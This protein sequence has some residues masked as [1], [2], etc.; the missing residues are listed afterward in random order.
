MATESES[1]RQ[2]KANYIRLHNEGY[3]P[4]EIA[5][6]FNLSYSHVLKKTFEIAEENGVDRDSLLIQVHKT[7][8]YWQRKRKEAHCDASKLIEQFDIAYEAISKVRNDI[9]CVLSKEVPEYVHLD[10]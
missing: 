3:S 8:A 4:R 9:N 2:M 10:R 6:M 1:V 7:P 5:Q